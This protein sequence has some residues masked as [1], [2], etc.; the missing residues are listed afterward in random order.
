VCKPVDLEQR[1]GRIQRFG[2]LTVRRP[3]AE[4]LGKQALRQ[5]AEVGA[6]PWDV[7]AQKADD[8]YGDETGMSP[9]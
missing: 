7:I 3:L 8:V 5:A 1:E 6:S 4:A 2:G 9:W